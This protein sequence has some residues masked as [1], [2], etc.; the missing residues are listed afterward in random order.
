MGLFSRRRKHAARLAEIEAELDRARDELTRVIRE[1][2]A[3]RSAEIE[4]LL[5]RERAD[6]LSLLQQEERRMG[7]ERR[8]LVADQERRA[9][10][11]LS[12][13][14]TEA[15]Q[16]VQQRLAGWGTD[17]ERTKQSM[18]TELNRLGERQKILV[19]EAEARL[20]NDREKIDEAGD[21]QAAAVTRLREELQRAAED[22]AEAIRAELD[23]HAAERRRALEEMAQRLESRERHLAESVEREETD[24][25]RRIEA[26]FADVE[27]RQI[28]GLE[29]ATDQAAG[30]F[31]EAAAL[32]FDAAVKSAREDAARRLARELDRAVHNFTREAESVLAEQLAQVADAGTQ[33]VE[34]RLAQVSAGLERHRDEF[35][36][37]LQQRVSHFEAEMRE[38]IRALAAEA[39]AERATL[40]RR[41]QEISRR[42][43]Q[44]DAVRR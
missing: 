8:R 6:S 17:L 12:A 39:E 9:T 37:A 14:M 44:L 16:R 19:R 24:V 26:R 5:A 20:Q 22:A 36:A 23:S 1:E 15:Q 33:R 42:A 41:L 4:R 28:E 18:T 38:R 11:E 21:V 2:T 29:R 31:A 13:A 30:R 27:R 34:K 10:A 25:V 40:D 32:Q 7:E 3:A 35:V 43:D